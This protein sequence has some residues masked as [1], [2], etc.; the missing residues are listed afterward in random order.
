M[1][2]GIQGGNIKDIIIWQCNIQIHG[3]VVSWQD[4]QILLPHLSWIEEISAI[5]SSY[6]VGRKV[7]LNADAC[8]MED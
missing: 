1:T 4:F 7:L 8:P 5:I 3:Y 6:L 2:V